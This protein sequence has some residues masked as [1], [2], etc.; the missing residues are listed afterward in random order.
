MARRKKRKYRIRKRN[1]TIIIF[2]ILFLLLSPIYEY[3]FQIKETLGIKSKEQNSST[4]NLPT[5]D[6]LSIYFLDV[7]QADSILITNNNHYFLIDGGNNEDGPKLVN[8]FK[9]MGI[10]SFDYVIGTHAHEDHIGGLDDI[11]DNFSISNFYLPDA[12]TTTKTFEDILDSLDKQ[13]IQITIPKVGEK[14]KMGDLEFEVLY[15]GTDTKDLNNTSIVLKM[16]YGSQKF[17]FTGDATSSTEKILSQQ[18]IDVDV[19]KVGHHGSRYSS[20]EEFLTKTS[21]QIAIISCAKNN[22]YGHPAPETLQK[23]K[24]HQIKTYL[25]SEDGTII[26]NSDGQN[27]EVNTVKTDT[28]G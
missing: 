17:L 15:T 12:M 24:S 6:N 18:D 5:T 28:N 4:Q 25:T 19:L 21:P 3:R 20:T 1:N 13:K 23:L 8:Y 11:I 14:I 22:N 10:K 16:Q 2:L 26:L 7:G 9:S 27:I